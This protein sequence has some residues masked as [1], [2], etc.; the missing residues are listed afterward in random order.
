V[1]DAPFKKAAADSRP[2]TSLQLWLSVLKH[3]VLRIRRHDPAAVERW[4]ETEILGKPRSLRAVGRDYPFLNA[5]VGPFPWISDWKPVYVADTDTKLRF[6][7]WM[8]K[9]TC[10]LKSCSQILN[11]V[12]ASEIRRKDARF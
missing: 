3:L 7:A 5:T 9:M 4:A 6:I 8:Q 1:P 11:H 2:E 12:K 10:A